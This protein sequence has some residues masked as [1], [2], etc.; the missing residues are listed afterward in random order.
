MSAASSAL[1]ALPEKSYLSGDNG[2]KSWLLTL[3]HKRIALLYRRDDGDYGLIHLHGYRGD[4]PGG[5]V[6]DLYRVADGRIVEH[7]D[8]IQPVPATAHNDHPLF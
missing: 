1:L 7:W 6:M 3:D 4:Q 5:A 8:V 2:L